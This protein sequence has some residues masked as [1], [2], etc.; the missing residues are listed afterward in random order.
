MNIDETTLGI[1]LGLASIMASII[2]ALLHIADTRIPGIRYWAVSALLIG[3]ALALDA[4][5]FGTTSKIADFLL[6]VPLVI[7]QVLFAAGV[8]N[9]VRRSFARFF[10]PLIVLVILA[11]T[12]VFTWVLP[13][14]LARGAILSIVY[15]VVCV[16]A[17]WLLFRYREP[18]APYA[19]VIAAIIAMAQAAAALVQ[20]ML[21]ITI[22]NNIEFTLAKEIAGALAIF[23]GAISSVV[24]GNWILFLLIMLRLVNEANARAER[25][26]LTGL[27]NRRGLRSH[28]DRLKKLAT[29]P[30]TITVMLLDIDYF[31]K[32]NDQN[33]HDFGDKI[34]IVMGRVLQ[35]F[36]CSNVVPCRWGGEEFCIVINDF[37]EQAIRPLAENIRSE[38]Q[39]QTSEA[40]SNKSWAT[41]SIGV[42][43]SKIQK[44][45][46]FSR[47]V[48]EADVQLYQAK[49]SGRNRVCGPK[50]PAFD[51]MHE[52]TI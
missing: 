25:D 52:F 36:A 8:A 7:G 50:G 28:I 10:L 9:F 18:P 42:A 3:C 44:D 46:E 35:D 47:I 26:T 12:F 2:F 30:Q 51:S 29:A 15:G 5:P 31:K 13:N 20:A 45:I 27:Y 16:W 41:T 48:S 33:G 23:A 17:A 49:T 19:Y 40:F 39:K 38:F 6:D 34:L 14:N 37:S 11:S 22:Q 4:S 43:T 21:L 32:I 1:V 24:L